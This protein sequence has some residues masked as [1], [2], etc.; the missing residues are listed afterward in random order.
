MDL[1]ESYI[2]AI[3]A[4]RDEDIALRTPKGLVARVVAL[5]DY[6]R[7][8]FL[9]NLRGAMCLHCGALDPHCQCQNDE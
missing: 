3:E 4:A 6:E 9:N 1:L 2:A 5:K 8:T 7:N